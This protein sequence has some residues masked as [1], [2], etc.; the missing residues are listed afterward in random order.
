VGDAGG[1][2]AQG[3]ELPRTPQSRIRFSKLSLQARHLLV[4]R[5]V[6]RVQSLR[7]LGHRPD[8]IAKIIAVRRDCC[9]RRAL[10]RSMSGC[11]IANPGWVKTALILIRVDQPKQFDLVR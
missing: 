4:Q 9:R 3:R 8:Q 10:I 1:H 11:S 6:R 2:F 5:T 7:R